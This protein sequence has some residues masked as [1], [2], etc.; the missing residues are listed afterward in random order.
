[1]GG[2]TSWRP[3]PGALLADASQYHLSEA[4][5]LAQ[6]AGRHL[7]ALAEVVG[8]SR[9]QRRRLQS[10]AGCCAAAA[11]GAQGLGLELGLK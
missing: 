4:Q 2:D 8:I 11:E 9:D 5:D 1:M 6:E 10:L 7:A 3:S